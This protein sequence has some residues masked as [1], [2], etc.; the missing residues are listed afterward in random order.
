VDIGTAGPP[1]EL[2]WARFDAPDR[3]V[4]ATRDDPRSSVLATGLADGGQAVLLLK[5]P[6]SVP[7]PGGHGAAPFAAWRAC[8]AVALSVCRAAG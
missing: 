1:S 4:A 8:G 2:A 5:A 7:V 3:E 6:M